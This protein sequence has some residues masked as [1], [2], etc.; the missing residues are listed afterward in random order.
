MAL[1][2]NCLTDGCIYH[3]HI[4]PSHIEV[5]VDLPTELDLTDEQ[6]YEVEKLLHNQVE[7]VIAFALQRS[8]ENKIK[9]MWKECP[10]CLW[11]STEVHECPKCG[12]A[13][14]YKENDNGC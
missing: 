9:E 7:L 13:R 2:T 11:M 1:E 12:T 5:V 8:R 10:H 6:A 3:T 4:E 14:D